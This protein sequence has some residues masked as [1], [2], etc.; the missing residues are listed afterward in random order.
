[1][2]GQL[3]RRLAE[4]PRGRVFVIILSFVIGLVLVW[5]LADE[6][7]ALAEN[8]EKLVTDL[9]DTQLEGDRL[10]DFERRVGET[11]RKLGELEARAVGEDELAEFRGRIVELARQAGCQVRRINA[12]SAKARSWRENDHVVEL[13]KG[14]QDNKETGYELKTQ[15]F[16][17][18]VGGTLPNLQRFLAALHA[19]RNLE[20]VRSFSLRPE[21]ADR[22][23]I[24]L[25]LELWLFDLSRKNSISA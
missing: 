20:H 9:Y 25:D 21:G 7:S 16:V 1:M 10:T 14:S 6:Y 11:T 24:V 3:L 12:S 15:S 18:T 22:K 2:V 4:H 5:P 19:Q 8:R 23:E 13:P 17:V